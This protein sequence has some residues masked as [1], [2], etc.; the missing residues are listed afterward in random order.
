MFFELSLEKKSIF[1][2]IFL[3]PTF[4]ELLLPHTQF[5]IEK[6]KQT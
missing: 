4:M 6:T 5:D 3:M 1:V 2:A